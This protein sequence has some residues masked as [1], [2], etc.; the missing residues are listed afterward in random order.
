MTN[1]GLEQV[2]VDRSGGYLGFLGRLAGIPGRDPTPSA[3][4]Y[5]LCR[6][7]LALVSVVLGL[8][9]TGQI[10]GPN[11]TVVFTVGMAAVVVMVITLLF[12]GRAK[13]TRGSEEFGRGVDEVISREQR[14]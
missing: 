3:V 6:A 2:D 9:A 12:T 7:I 1:L 11:P 8:D 14:G 5:Y 10:S 13:R 4:V